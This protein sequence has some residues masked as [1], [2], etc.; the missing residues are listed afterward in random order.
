MKTIVKWLLITAIASI[1]FITILLGLGYLLKEN[2]ETTS[3][4]KTKLN[5]E[6]LIQ[7]KNEARKQALFRV[8]PSSPTTEKLTVFEQS[9]QEIIRNNLGCNSE[10]DCLLL[11]T[12]NH[13]LGCIV[14]VNTKGVAILLRTATEKSEIKRAEHSCQQAYS[15]EIVPTLACQNN[16]CTL[17]Y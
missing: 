4:L 5:Q 13:N 11:H 10:K 7:Q 6:A 8:K 2:E 17:A 16:T 12:N 1:F 3:Q 15:Q 9:Q 14:A